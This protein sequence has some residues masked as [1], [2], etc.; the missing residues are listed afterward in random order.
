MIID[1]Y[2]DHH[3]HHYHQHFLQ[4]PT[5]I[6]ILINDKEFNHFEK[7]MFLNSYLFQKENLIMDLKNQY[8]SINYFKHLE[9]LTKL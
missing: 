3:R 9:G 1:H 5:K 4:E 7:V 8:C 2:H 6:I